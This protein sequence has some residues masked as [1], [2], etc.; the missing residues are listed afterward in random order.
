MPLN[1]IMIVGPP[2]A[3]K[4]TFAKVVAKR[5]HLPCYHL[6]HYYWKPNWQKHSAEKW[7]DIHKQLIK[8]PA[9]IIEGCAIKSS[10]RERFVAADMVIYFKPS[11]FICLWR[12]IR[13][14]FAGRPDAL[15]QGC[16]EGLPWR[17]IQYM[18]TFEE[19]MG[20]YLP[21]AQKD[22]PDVKVIIV[23]TS[24]DALRVLNSF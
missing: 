19:L 15:P 7:Q 17:L 18:W 10:F 20:S 6:D 8:N 11:R 24:A 21:Q 5:L 14:F 2:G 13:R 23:R 4:S 3:G 16:C 22:F 1:R 12:M 9:W